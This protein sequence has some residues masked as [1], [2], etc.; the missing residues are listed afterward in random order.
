MKKEVLSIVT[1]KGIE[2]AKIEAMR[3]GA[4]D[5]NDIEEIKMEEDF[6]TTVNF[7]IK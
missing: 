6:V 7:N 4:W 5:T 2:W 1:S 3:L